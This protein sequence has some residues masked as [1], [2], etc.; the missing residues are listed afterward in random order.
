MKLQRGLKMNNEDFNLLLDSVK[1]A[2]A[3][4]KGLAKPS[5]VTKFSKETVAQIRKNSNKSQTEFADMIGVSVS[6]LRNWEQGTRKPNKSAQVLLKLVA[7]NPQFVE[8]TL[9]KPVVVI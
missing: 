3:I 7:A 4:E 9:K 6:T 5:R 8:E 2:V 1:E